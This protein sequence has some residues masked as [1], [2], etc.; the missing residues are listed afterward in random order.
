MTPDSAAADLLPLRRVLP[1]GL[2]L[3]FIQLPV[4][5]RAAALVRVHAGAHDTPAEY[6]GLAHFLEHLLFLGSQAYAANES[7]MPFV[8]G[9][10]GQL[11]A[12]TR[13]RHTDFFFQV[14]TDAFDEAL[15]RLLDMLARPLLDEAAQLRER[16][17]LQAE[18]LARGRDRETLCDAAIGTA[19]TAPHP[20]SAFHAGNRDTLAVETSDF[21]Q[22]LKDYH[23]RFYHSGQMELLVAT[24]CSLEQLLELLQC[25]DECQ[26]PA[27][28]SV[29]RR[30]APLRVD[31]GATLRLKVDGAPPALNL[32]FALDGLPEETCVALDVLGSW[33]ASQADGSLGAAV[34]EAGW[35]DAVA[36]RVPYWHD[37]QGVV[38]LEMQL[39][40]QGM[41]D[42]AQLGAAVRSWLQFMTAQAPW[43]E[44]WDEYVQIRQRGLR[45]KEPLALLRYWV[46]PSAWA[47]SIDAKRVRQALQALGTQLDGAKPIVLT[48]DG[49]GCNKGKRIEA[50][51]VGF[52]LDLVSEPLP[53]LHRHAWQ[54]RLPERN[55]WLSERLHPQLAPVVAPSLCWLEHTDNA[56]Q[57]ALYVRWRFSSGQPPAGLW[58]VLHATLRMHV[59]AAAQAGVEL[60]FEDYGRSWCLMLFGHAEA[61]P[62]I[63]RDLLG[64]L[65]A[66]ATAAFDEGRRL[67]SE[68]ATSGAD[69]ML[70]RQM[71]RRIPLLLSPALLADGATLD[72]QA[73]ARAWQRSNWDALAIG[74]PAHLSGPLQTILA[75][76][77]GQAEPGVKQQ[78]A[79]APRYR[80]SRFGEP[81]VETALVLFCP[82]PVRTAA[83]EAA[84]RLLAKLMEGAFFRRLRSE[85]QLGYAV[86]C[87]FRQFGDQAGIVFAVQSP[88]ASADAI[89]EHI[90]SFLATFAGGLDVSE[91]LNIGALE[92][93]NDDLRS[94]AESVWQA[95]LAGFDVDHPAAVVAASAALGVRDILA[96][97]QALRAA[98]GGWQVVA[99]ADAPDA[100]WQNG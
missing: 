89:L 42:R 82:L 54:W 18:F 53:A 50:A 5:S 9:R 67:H 76:M 49:L 32:A 39:T 77:P 22:A 84:W 27:A 92:R 15:K 14:S 44:L 45:G 46:D 68:A 88:C 41:V 56:G 8:Q 63:L 13:E 58:Y 86:F 74:L 96:Q 17:V 16:E 70:I 80:W 61:L 98:E 19:L 52:A 25:T 33:L 29:V 43:P 87:G 97:L 94:R 71:L 95:R 1:N 75:D 36:L 12:S 2:R 10:A 62:L 78:H 55:P 34:R 40:K 99:N 21:Q 47:P 79:S 20:F 11:N 60:R 85:L 100:R 6:P 28:P 3:G 35:C 90:E 31:D 37:G 26:L 73:L 91:A 81:G 64:V 83:V 48:V 65:R 38:V 51:R 23:R 24:P 4:G 72:P 30:V 59:P 93:P 69:E 57:G 66:P 7:L